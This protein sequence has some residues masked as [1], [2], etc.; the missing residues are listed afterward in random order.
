[1]KRKEKNINVTYFVE[2]GK[3]ELS[4]T[5]FQLPVAPFVFESRGVLLL[6]GLKERV[7]AAHTV[8]VCVG[9]C[10]C[11]VCM[12]WLHTKNLFLFFIPNFHKKNKQTKKPVFRCTVDCS[13]TTTL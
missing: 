7:T 9:V 1:M 5:L 6:K 4:G 11:A 3:K 10:A 8:C 2:K 12:L 13:N